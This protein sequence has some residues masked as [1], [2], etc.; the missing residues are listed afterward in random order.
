MAQLNP[1]LYIRQQLSSDAYG[2][3]KFDFVIDPQLD[4]GLV[5]EATERQWDVQ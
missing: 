4:P 2:E 5:D 3:E 1:V